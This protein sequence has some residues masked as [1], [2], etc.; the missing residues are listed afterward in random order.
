MVLPSIPIPGFN[1]MMAKLHKLWRSNGTDELERVSLQTMTA[2]AGPVPFV[3]WGLFTKS[4]TLPALLAWFAKH[5]L[6]FLE[7]DM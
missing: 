7:G 5:L 2:L 3:Y 4:E 6:S 1:E